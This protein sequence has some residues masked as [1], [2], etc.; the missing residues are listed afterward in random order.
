MFQ[1][2]GWP[3][4]SSIW[5]WLSP[6]RRPE[7]PPAVRIALASTTPMASA[8]ALVGLD[9][10]VAQVVESAQDVVMPPGRERGLEPVGVD[11][12]A[13]RL[14]PE[15]AAF[16][17]VRLPAIAG[18]PYPRRASD[19]PLVFE[20]ALETLIVVSKDETVAPF[21][22]SQFQPPSG[23]CSPSS[24]STSGVMSTPK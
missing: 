22:T 14:P 6:R 23:S 15:Q 17:Q 11:H 13:G 16:Q 20:Q 2:L 7:R 5:T 10:G 18:L 1:R 4:P 21:S 19:R 9:L 3:S 8:I 12:L 24:R